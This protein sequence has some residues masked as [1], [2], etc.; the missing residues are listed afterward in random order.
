[1]N[2]GGSLL[3]A[4]FTL[5][6]QSPD[7]TPHP[8]HAPPFLALDWADSQ[9]VAVPQLLGGLLPGFYGFALPS[10]STLDFN[11]ELSI[12]ASSTANASLSFLSM[13]MLLTMSADAL[14]GL[15]LAVLLHTGSRPFRTCV[16]PPV[17]TC[18]RMIVAAA[19]T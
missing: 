11:L 10:T 12:P 8:D 6:C 14:Q 1:M 17:H 9:G 19:T 13:V 18:Q 2:P 4:G 7:A 5:E 3:V 15:Q 16:A